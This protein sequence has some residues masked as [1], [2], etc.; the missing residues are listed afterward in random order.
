MYKHSAGSEMD[1]YV[2]VN[3]FTRR[4]YDNLAPALC[5]KHS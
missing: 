5:S 4:A 3:A 2:D 1:D